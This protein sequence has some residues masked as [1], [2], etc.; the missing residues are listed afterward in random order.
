M[1]IGKIS[2]DIFNV[3]KTGLFYRYTLDKTLSKAHIT[4]LVRANMDRSEN[5]PLLVIEK[6]TNP[7]CFKN[8]KS[9]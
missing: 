4:L 1:L 2:K 8:V 3:N 7:I 9:N 6:S 5:L